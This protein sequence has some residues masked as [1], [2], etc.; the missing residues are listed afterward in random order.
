VCH[1][2]TGTT[3]P[4]DNLSFESDALASTPT[5]CGL[6]CRQWLFLLEAVPSLLIGVVIWCW[7]PSHPLTAWMLTPAQQE[8]V[9]LKVWT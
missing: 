4:T 1:L 3:K 2:Q 6:C 8:L 7:L 5:C 9:H